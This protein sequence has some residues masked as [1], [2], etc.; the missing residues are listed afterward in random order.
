MATGAGPIIGRAVCIAG[1]RGFVGGMN[2]QWHLAQDDGATGGS[3]Y[4]QTS[5]PM[6]DRR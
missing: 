2:A 5:F 4:L 6:A 3:N 1:D